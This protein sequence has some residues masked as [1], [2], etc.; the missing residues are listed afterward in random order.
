MN[1]PLVGLGA[2]SRRGAPPHPATA[3][4]AREFGRELRGEVRFD[5]GYRAL[6]STDGSNYRQ[7]PIGVVL[8]RDA[9]DVA[10]AVAACRR[11]GVPVLPRGAAT[12]LA[13]Q[14]C[15]LPLAIHCPTHT[16]PP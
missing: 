3:D 4:L 13:A 16:P 10:A 5:P 1:A 11:H 12:S 2:A 7:V 8:P 15:N 9:Q 14:S 6:Y